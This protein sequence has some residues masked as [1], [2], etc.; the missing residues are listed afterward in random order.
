LKN[1]DQV[2]IKHELRGIEI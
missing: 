2:Y 1:L